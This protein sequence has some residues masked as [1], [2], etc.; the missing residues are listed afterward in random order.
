MAETHCA[1]TFQLFFH[2][3]TLGRCLWDYVKCTE[4]YK[5]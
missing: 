4:G 1:G 2:L 3:S 5:N